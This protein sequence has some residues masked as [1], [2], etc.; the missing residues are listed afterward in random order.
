MKSD[1][2]PKRS[3]SLPSRGQWIPV[4]Y[5]KAAA[6]LERPKR[7]A[8]REGR[9]EQREET[10]EDGNS[11]IYEKREEEERREERREGLEKYGKIGK[12]SPGGSIMRS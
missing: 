10:G 9:R 7:R 3:A 6:P 4:R 2:S 8:K 11:N 5:A 12:T 1:P